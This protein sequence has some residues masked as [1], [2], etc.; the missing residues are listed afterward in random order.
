MNLLQRTCPLTWS[1]GIR[2]Q[3][4]CRVVICVLTVGF[5]FNLLSWCPWWL[6]LCQQPVYMPTNHSRLC[7]N[8]KG[9]LAGGVTHHTPWL[10]ALGFSAGLGHVYYGY[11]A[12]Q[13]N[14]ENGESWES[15]IRLA[16]LWYSPLPSALPWFPNHVFHILSLTF[17]HCL[18][19][20][21]RKLEKNTRSR[22]TWTWVTSRFFPEFNPMTKSLFFCCSP[23]CHLRRKAWKKSKVWLKLANSAHLEV[24]LPYP[25]W[26]SCNH[27]PVKSHSSHYPRT[28]S[29]VHRAANCYIQV[30]ISLWYGILCIGFSYSMHG[31]TWMCFSTN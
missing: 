13:T 5:S 23:E 3:S 22:V 1:T 25:D 2:Q 11:K 20:R 7:W 31:R 14:G 6:I 15:R 24:N 16:S 29:L 19:S 9:R 4:L 17:P 26:W 18:F 8:L 27:L 30:S 21:S 10:A 28:R 12:Q